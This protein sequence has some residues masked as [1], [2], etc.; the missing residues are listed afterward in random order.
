MTLLILLAATAAIWM[1]VGDPR[2]LLRGEDRFTVAWVFLVAAWPFITVYVVGPL[3]WASPDQAGRLFPALQYTPGAICSVVGV[4]RGLRDSRTQVSLPAVLTGTTLLFAAVSVWFSGRVQVLNFLMAGALFMGVVLKRGVTPVRTLSVA[5]LVSLSTMS[6]AVTFAVVVNPGR[7]LT[8]CRL[9][10]CGVV[11]QVLTS[12]LSANGNVLGI[13]TVLLIPFA[14]ASLTLRR[15]LV[16]LTGV[17]AFQLL[18]MSR[19]AIFALM[20]ASVA[21]LLIKSRQSLRWQLAVASTALAVGF[22][23]SFFPLVVNF[24][25]SSYAERG[26]V[27]QAG[28]EAIG[29]APLFGHGP[30]YWWLIAQN[31]LFDVN[32]SP[33][34][35]WYD[36]VISVGA[37]GV[38]VIVVGVIVQLATTASAALPYL[39]TYY[40]CV[41]SINVFESVYV[42]YFL[43]IM[44]IAALLPLMLYESKPAADRER[45]AALTDAFDHQT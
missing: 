21:L 15:C 8:H 19:T 5:A 1:A 12:S 34:N 27:W 6:A 18:T 2:V 40:A 32:Y 36:I 3:I 35:G 28:R 24:S 4:V 7:V 43:G 11:T 37:W 13:A 30:S 44:P 16:L 14:C 41:L 26:Y 29:Q 22:C 10:K 39:F 20:T 42:P 9:D 33:H 25:G 31:A 17:G 45:E 38:L 23:A